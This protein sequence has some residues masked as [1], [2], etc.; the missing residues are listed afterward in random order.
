MCGATVVPRDRVI[1]GDEARARV[2]R[3]VG[4]GRRV[5]LGAVARRDDH[6]LARHL[7]RRERGQRGVEPRAR[8]VDRFPQ[9]Y[10]RG[11]VTDAHRHELHQKLWLLVRK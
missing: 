5:D 11:P 3:D 9:F 2:G 10:W 6:G 7:P 1:L 8:E 4:V